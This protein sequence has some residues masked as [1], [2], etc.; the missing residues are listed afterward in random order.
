MQLLLPV[1]CQPLLVLWRTVFSSI[2]WTGICLLT[3]AHSTCLGGHDNLDVSK[4]F[5]SCHYHIAGLNSILKNTSCPAGNVYGVVPVNAG[6]DVSIILMVIHQFVAY[7]LYV[8][9]VFFMWEKLRRTHHSSY[10]IRLPSRIPVCKCHVLCTSWSWCIL[11][12]RDLII[13]EKFLM[14]VSVTSLALAEPD[15]ISNTH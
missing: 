8:T 15:A 11:I 7:A 10:W 4:D 12:H 5:V 9:P 6:R 14:S 2:T 3:C 13:P 1:L